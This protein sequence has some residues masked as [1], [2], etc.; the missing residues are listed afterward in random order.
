MANNC[1]I[2][3]L[4]KLY[5]QGGTY[6]QFA[7]SDHFSGHNFVSVVVIKDMTWSHGWAVALD[8]GYKS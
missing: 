5:G 3:T 8:F 2:P 1:T 4:G 7:P 6:L